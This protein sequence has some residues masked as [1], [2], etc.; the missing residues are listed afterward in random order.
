VHVPLPVELAVIVIAD[1]QLVHGPVEADACS[2][3]AVQLV[4]VPTAVMFAPSVTMVD[5]K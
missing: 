1:P 2:I 3:C 4:V 5:G